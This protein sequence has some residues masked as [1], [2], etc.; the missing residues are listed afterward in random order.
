MFALAAGA[1]DVRD[2]DESRC[3]DNVRV[4]ALINLACDAIMRYNSYFDGRERNKIV[5]LKSVSFQNNTNNSR[6]KISK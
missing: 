5:G 6:I 4:H 1:V 3:R 2:S